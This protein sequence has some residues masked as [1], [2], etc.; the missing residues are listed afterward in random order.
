MRVYVFAV[1]AIGAA[2][3]FGGGRATAESAATYLGH[4]EWTQTLLGKQ[5]ATPSPDLVDAPVGK[6]DKYQANVVRRTKPQGAI[7]HMAGTE[8]HSILEGSATLVTGG[9]IVR[10]ATGDRGGATIK[11]GQTWHVVKGDV[12]LVPPQTPHWYKDIDGSVTYLETR[13]DVGAAPGG[14]A[15][16]LMNSDAHKKL[17]E[18]GAASG[19]PLMFSTPVARGDHYQSNIVRRTMAQ[20]GGAHPGWTEIH[21]ILEGSGTF[22]TGGTVV[23]GAANGADANTIQGGTSRPVSAGDVVLIPA[24]MPH[25]YKTVDA[26]GITYVETRF[27]L[28]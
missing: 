20:G 4:A 11:D 10:P 28:Q 25:W 8:I 1:A 9:T 16:A 7:A 24:G 22:V 2:V 6:G 27:E 15:I 17:A 26:G 3:V 13:F 19:A 5:K 23:R 12:I 21:H 14:P 18:R